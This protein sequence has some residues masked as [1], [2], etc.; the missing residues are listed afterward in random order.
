MEDQLEQIGDVIDNAG[1]T[2]RAVLQA[3]QIQ[4]QS[5]LDRLAQAQKVAETVQPQLVIERNTAGQDSRALFGTDTS[6]PSFKLTVRDNEAQQ[7][8]L[9]QAGVHSPATLQALLQGRHAA[10]LVSVIQALQTP[11]F[12]TNI[13]ALQSLLHTSVTSHPAGDAPRTIEGSS[14][15]KGSST[16]AFTRQISN[17]QNAGL[18]RRNHADAED[19]EQHLGK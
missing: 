5:C 14:N 4:L 6:Q 18:L 3:D 8:A 19:I 17:S 15:I 16:A 11:S 2:I 10:D 13:G 1:S 9:M 7:G 12:S